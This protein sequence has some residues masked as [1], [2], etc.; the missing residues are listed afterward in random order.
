MDTLERRLE[1][2][3]E[4]G[5]NHLDLTNVWKTKSYNRNSSL[6]GYQEGDNIWL[7]EPKRKKGISP[8]LHKSWIGPGK[9]LKKISDVTYRIQMGPQT[10]PKIVHHNKLLP[11]DGRNPPTWEGK[12]PTAP[13][14]VADV[15]AFSEP[16]K[17]DVTSSDATDETP[18]N[19]QTSNTDPP[20]STSSVPA[21]Q[22][23]NPDQ[24]S[25]RRPQR[26]RRPVDRY[27]QPLLY[28]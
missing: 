2:V 24:S 18:G 8:K 27:G 20:T 12:R 3:H 10:K 21:G 9:I 5:R 1:K 14:E 25:D 7:Y 15:C 19:G 11:Y 13:T 26:T 28:G 16:D 6:R 17:E 22:N 4:S 23:V